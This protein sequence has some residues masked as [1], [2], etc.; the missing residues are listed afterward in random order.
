MCWDDDRILLVR[1]ST[2]DDIEPGTWALPGGGIEH[3]ESPEDALHREFG[4]E[5]GLTIEVTGLRDVTA[6]L[7]LLRHKDA[8][9]HSDRVLYDVRV[10]GGTLRNEVD[11]T[12]DLVEWVPAAAPA[13]LPLL[14]YVSRLLGLPADDPAPPPAEPVVD[15]APTRRQR[16]ATYALATDP[17]GRVLLTRIAPGYPGAGSWHLPGGGTD[18]GE[19]PHAGLLRELAEETDQRGQ[20]TGLLAVSMFHN[21]AALGPEGRP[22]DWHTVRV[23]FRVRVPGP[24]TP[25]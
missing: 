19:E 12:S 11:G 2:L 22:I 7:A 16:F 18:W 15:P 8:V 10:T 17:A 20:V 24:T 9:M 13:E 3:G 25:R 1:S 14:P 21:P 4:E 23:L 6:D 5:T